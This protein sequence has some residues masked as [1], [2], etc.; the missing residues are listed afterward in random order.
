MSKGLILILCTGNS[1]R[2]QMAEAFLREAVDGAVE[3]ASAGSNPAGYVVPGAV[4]TMAELGIDISGGKSEHM[5]DF[6]DRGVTV[7]I[8]V[9]GH[10][11]QA[12]PTYPGD[13]QRFHWPF[14]DP[15]HAVG[16]EEEVKAEF[17]RVRDEL[18]EKFGE[19]GRSQ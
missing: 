1:C 13:V 18:R 2:S 15:S 5:N 9:C 16:T 19:Y 10:A 7:V 17:R 6:L 14:D 8:T 12:C 11:D 4:E 3:V